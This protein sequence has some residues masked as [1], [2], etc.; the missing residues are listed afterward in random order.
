MNLNLA[1]RLLSAAAFAASLSLA[2]GPSKGG[3]DTASTGDSTGTSTDAPQCTPGDTKSG[4]G[5]CSTCECSAEGTW[6]CNRC[7]PTTGFDTT[8]GSG[9]T[10]A[11]STS[12][13][14]TSVDSTDTDTG[15]TAT[16]DGSTATSDGSTTTS[17]GSTTTGDT[18]GEALPSCVDLGEG[19]MFAIDA[20]KVVGDDLVLDVGYS[21]GC[22]MHDFTLCFAGIVLDTDILLVRVHHDAM[23]DA[24]EAFIT[25]QRIVDLTPLQQ[26]M[27]SPVKLELDGWPELL[28]Y[29]Y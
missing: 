13:G 12:A 19:D 1:S 14:S 18:G 26:L 4:E 25:E 29:V 9:S 6:Q 16:S 23:G 15:S 22:T 24:C 28:Q 3:S 21:G 2:C 10:S 7:T 17:D 27:P 11:G 8:T 5:D 20:A